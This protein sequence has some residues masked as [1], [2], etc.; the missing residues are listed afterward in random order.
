MTKLKLFVG[1]AFLAL[2]VALFA[3]AP[4]RAESLAVALDLTLVDVSNFNLGCVENFSFTRANTGWNMNVRADSDTGNAGAS[5]AIS[6][7]VNSSSTGVGIWESG[8]GP[9][10]VNVG[11]EEGGFTT[12][13]L[14]ALPWLFE[15]DPIAV[16]A[17][18]DLVR[19]SNFNA[20]GVGNMVFTGANSGW[21]WTF[22]G[23][24]D[25]GNAKASAVVSTN[26][27]SSTTN[28]AIYDFESGPVAVNWSPVG[29]GDGE[30]ECSSC[31]PGALALAADLTAVRVTN[32]NAGYVA[33]VVA[34]WANTGNNVTLKGSSDTGNASAGSSV[35]TAMN[36]SNTSVTVTESGM[37][38]VAANVGSGSLAVAAEA[39]LVAVD[40]TNLGM[41]VNGVVTKANTG[42]NFTSKG[43][44]DTGDAAASSRV[45]NSVNS[46]TT[47]VSVADNDSPA[48]VNADPDGL[49]DGP[50]CGQTDCLGDGCGV[51][52]GPVAANVGTEG[53][54]VAADVTVVTVDNSNGALVS[55]DV[56]TTANTGDNY[57]VGGC[58]PDEDLGEEQ[59]CGDPCG[60]PCSPDCGECVECP[61]SDT[62]DASAS[63]TV[64][65]TVN[66]SS[67]TVVI[68]GGVM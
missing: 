25:T 48:A 29:D 49:C 18:V 58:C 39:D 1:T 15:H 26:L 46:S 14:P 60:D 3:A 55:N 52:G 54:A 63:T 7:D 57:T 64:S 5:A 56:D 31:M 10:A 24:S 44:S 53:A 34:T 68:G 66:T 32:F 12:A 20:G 38:S 19:V 16:A 40:N 43:D 61:E 6:N 30:L 17:D 45:S 36:S 28:V 21:N 50:A 47:S 41:V 11:G 62:G 2:V 67:T 33:N 22:M 9:M 23:G 8:L 65:N 42:Q 13:Q 27:N 51:A 35:S 4:A 37:G 59:S